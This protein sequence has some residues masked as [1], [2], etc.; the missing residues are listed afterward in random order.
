MKTKMVKGGD[1][2]PGHRIQNDNG[3]WVRLTKAETTRAFRLA[4][5]GHRERYAVMLEWSNGYALVHPEEEVEVA[6]GNA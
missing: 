2:L 5:E 6:D 4:L 1:L 3:R